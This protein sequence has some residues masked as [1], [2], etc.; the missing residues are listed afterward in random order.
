M[1]QPLVC[2]NVPH[3]QN[4]MLHNLKEMQYLFFFYFF[5][6]FI[7]HY[8]CIELET[9]TLSITVLKAESY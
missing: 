9:Q 8:I 6:I 1:K 7:L 3:I 4:E 2:F 5:I